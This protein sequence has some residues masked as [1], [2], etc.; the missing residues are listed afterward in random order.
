[1]YPV[2][3][4]YRERVMDT[5]RVWDLRIRVVLVNGTTLHLTKENLQLGSLVY[6]DGAVCSEAIH[7]GSTYSSSVEFTIANDGKQYSE[8][9][10]YGAKVFPEVGLDLANNGSFEYVPLGEFNVL[11]PVKKMSTIP[12]VC[13]DNMA[14]ANKPFDFSTMLFPTTVSTV[15]QAVL[16]Q[17]G[18]VATDSLALEISDL[19][20]PISSLL[21]NDATCRDVL[22][23]IGVM[24]LKNLR[25][26]R[27]GVLESFWYEPSTVYT[28]AD[29]RV[30]NSNFGD[31]AHN[32]TGVYVEDA[33]GNVFSH[34]TSEYPVELPTSPI[35]QGA[36]MVFPI[37]EATLTKLQT[38][39]Y[40]PA[41]VTWL[42]DPAVQAGDI[43]NHKSTP[44]GDV[45]LLAMRV[46]YKFAGTSTID[47]LGPDAATLE[48]STTAERKLK[49]VF[50]QNKHN[51]EEL[52]TK[53]DQTADRVEI[54]ASQVTVSRVG[55]RNLIRNSSSLVFENYYFTSVSA[56]CGTCICGEAICGL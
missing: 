55:A 42:G 48:Q 9:E 18:F 39:M 26:N 50:A 23:G 29:M 40:R 49:K 38:S 5:A 14:L 34:G 43:I 12:L 41:T 1:M 19:E 20:Y 32:V 47:S 31:V 27:L 53:I 56:I 35:L 33:Y 45:A 28:N 30:G 8:Y 36:D 7:T 54:L 22:A 52:R 16:K 25:F 46:V 37:L 2:S 4:L 44:V 21:T 51:Y 11:E 6:K 24:L 13:F 10:F 15:Y 3:S 17:C